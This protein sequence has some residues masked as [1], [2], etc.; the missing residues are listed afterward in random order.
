MDSNDVALDLRTLAAREELGDLVDPVAGM[1]ARAQAIT[2]WVRALVHGPV[3]PQVDE[4][5]VRRAYRVSL[6]SRGSNGLDPAESA[7]LL[8]DID[9]MATII[10]L[11]GAMVDT[12]RA[13]MWRLATDLYLMAQQPT[14]A[15]RTS[16]ALRRGHALETDEDLA[17]DLLATASSL[18]GAA[19]IGE[20]LVR[21]LVNL[22]GSET[23]FADPAEALRALRALTLDQGDPTLHR[24]AIELEKAWG[25]RVHHRIDSLAGLLPERYVA[26]CLSRDPAIRRAELLPPQ[27]SAVRSGLLEAGTAAIATPTGSGKTFL[28][29]LRLVAALT[30]E[31][32]LAVY[33]AP[34]NA[35]ARQVQ[36]VLAERLRSLGWGVQLWTGAYE[37][38]STIDDL[39][40]VLITTP[41]K[42]DAIIRSRIEED[43]RAEELM[44]RARAF[45]FDESH[46]IAAGARGITYEL[47]MTRVRA[48][49]TEARVMTMSAV[50]SEPDGFIRWLG[51]T[52]GRTLASKMSWSPTQTWDV[53]WRRDGDMELRG[54]GDPIAR[55]AR[56][57]DPRQAAAQLAATLLFELR[58]LL[59]VE[60]RKE[61]AEKLARTIVERYPD[62]LEE[63]LGSVEAREPGAASELKDLA[64]QMR[65][66]VH[67]QYSLARLV[68]KGVAF[69]H[70]G[71]PV[72]LRKRIEDLARREIIHTLVSTTTLAEGVDLPSR[73]VVV[74]HLNL[75]GGPLPAATLRNIRGRAGR[76]QFANHALFFIIEPDNLTTATYQYFRDHFWDRS[77]TTVAG[78]S[79]LAQIPSSPR[80]LRRSMRR[81][82]ESQLLA[83]Y[84][85]QDVLPEDVARLADET[86][87]GSQPDG[88]SGSIQGIAR[89]FRQTTDYLLEEPALVRA[90][91]PIK[92]TGLG[93]GAMLGGMSGQSA[94]FV[95]EALL[96]H[97]AALPNLLE[98]RGNAWM[99]VRLSW[100]PWEAVERSQ[101]YRSQS[102]MRNGVFERDPASLDLLEDARLTREYALADGALEPLCFEEMID[103]EDV[104]PHL[105]GKRA[106]RDSR[107]ANVIE[108]AGGGGATLAWT[109]TGV[110]RI[111]EG[112]GEDEG[113]DGLANLGQQM[114]A[115]IPRIREWMPWESG[116]E[117][118]AAGLDRDS[119]IKVLRLAG[120]ENG[121]ALN[122]RHWLRGAS[123]LLKKT[124]SREAMEVLERL[125]DVD[126]GADFPF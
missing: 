75:P 57:N 108:W 54:L 105:G 100:L 102:A 79:A 3:E 93:R 26:A 49:F 117:L 5:Y 12:R 90:A 115:W 119:A 25:Y 85:E 39:G 20:I 76:P 125:A 91:S 58:S 62:V 77:V 118:I 34:L 107:L 81:A 99:A 126:E 66:E 6:L 17:S 14:K 37:L 33:V 113:N 40:H 1:E 101:P 50:G 10:E 96:L 31:P 103:T 4:H 120:P 35:L 110:V 60:T 67:P 111:A 38:D 95:R 106:S 29:E 74:V 124:L 9:R 7:E 15:A 2:S 53:L 78:A 24:F 72:P 36:R 97:E 22:L 88:P 64:S 41:E 13:E 112:L 89:S 52:G 59:L 19:T 83:L 61:W 98:E 80:L 92:P 63:R 45:V 82:L 27:L 18:R 65:R 47:L 94:R 69:H 16:V 71:V 8:R 28:A 84:S 104:Q 122:L 51:K 42:L 30:H 121:D 109:L 46:M 123:Q 73:A 23:G 48:L 86:F 55:L 11:Y 44:T 116:L 87:V 70:S 21:G 68:E 32:G 56:P 114:K 43:A